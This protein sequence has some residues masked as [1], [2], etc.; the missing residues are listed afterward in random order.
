MPEHTCPLCWLSF[1]NALEL[2]QHEELE[3]TLDWP[4]DSYDPSTYA[5]M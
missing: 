5:D 4:L 2:S 1:D 3:A